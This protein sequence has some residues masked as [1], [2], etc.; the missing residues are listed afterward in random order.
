MLVDTANGTGVPTIATSG[1][2]WAMPG[3]SLIT[4]E[5]AREI[6]DGPLVGGDDPAADHGPGKR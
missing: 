5:R 4:S 2:E 3:E 6:F 1:L